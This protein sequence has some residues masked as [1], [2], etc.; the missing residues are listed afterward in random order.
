MLLC[1]ILYR[2]GYLELTK[3]TPESLVKGEKIKEIYHMIY[4]LLGIYNN[5]SVSHTI[6]D[7]PYLSSQHVYPCSKFFFDFYI[8]PT[9]S[10]SF[11]TLIALHVT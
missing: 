4:I 9:R 10:G 5:T 8:N 7:R 1:D 2:Y 6:S 3:I 11:L